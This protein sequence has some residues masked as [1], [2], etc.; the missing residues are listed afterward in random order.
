MNNLKNLSKYIAEQS[1]A[2][3][4]LK[5]LKVLLSENE[6]KTIS[7]RIE[8]LKMLNEKIP[9]EKI[10]KKLKVGIATVTR[11]ARQYKKHKNLTWW[12]DFISWWN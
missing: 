4:I 12:K 2:E 8:I 11:G 1:N 6:I 10:A 5:I 9:Q 7:S 3:E